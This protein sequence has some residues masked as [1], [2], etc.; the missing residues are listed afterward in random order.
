MIRI[1]GRA[2]APVVATAALLCGAGGCVDDGT[3][4]VETSNEKVKVK[5]FVKLKGQPLEDGEIAFDPANIKRKDAGLFKAKVT[6]GAYET[7][8]LVG[9]NS[10]TVRSKVIDRDLG[11]SANSKYVEL[12]AG[13]VNTVDIEL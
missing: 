1:M 12:K 6:A 11:L 2:L 9:G 3:P 4:S 8:S 13:E 10:V 7:E 5:G